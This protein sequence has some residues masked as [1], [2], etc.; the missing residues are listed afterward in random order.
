MAETQPANVFSPSTIKVACKD[1]TLFQLCLPIGVSDADLELLDRIIKKRRAV[2]PGEHLFRMGDP[3]VSIYA[4]KSGSF[5]TFTF[6]DDG[7]EQVT[8]LH[9]P[10]ELFG[11][12]AISSGTHCCN[13]VALERSA[14]CEIPFDR[15]QDLGARVPSL[16]RQMVR[17]MSKE[18]MRDKRVMQIT[19]SGAEGRLAA[20]LLSVA[21]RYFERGFS[22]DEYHLSM[23]RVD[24]GNYLGLADETVSRLFTRFKDEGLLM[25]DRRHVRLL[26]IP[27]LQA[28]ARGGT[29]RGASGAREEGSGARLLAWDP[30][31]S[32]GIDAI[33]RQHQRLF[34]ISNRFYDAWR[35][36]AGHDALRRV[37][38]ELL[39]YTGY[40]F[41]EEER[42]MREIGYPGFAGHHRAHEELVE[43]VGKYRSQLEAGVPGIETQA[44]EFIKTWLNIHVLEDDRSIGDYL[45][46][47]GT[48]SVGH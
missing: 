18:I 31:Y 12:D 48:K 19:K 36:R 44:L 5:K 47:T 4:V 23:S 41:A 17:I 33:D 8:G 15:L 38:D 35:T 14:V 45:R 46:R 26:D 11:M 16:M 1:C 32:I 37:F 39:E 24:I 40:H 25:V 13:A 21:E 7:A 34:E 3:F 30:I 43:L 20:F 28:I 9:L 42:L 27:R 22:Q 6:A 2:K 10:G 29:E